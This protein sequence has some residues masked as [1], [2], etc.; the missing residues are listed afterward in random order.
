[1]SLGHGASI[2]KNGLVLHL[3][4]ANPKSYVGSG[5]S[6][7]DI[8]GNGNNGTLV[9]GVGYSVDNKG[10]LIFD[11]VDDYGYVDESNTNKPLDAITVCSFVYPVLPSYN[12]VRLIGDW[13]Q[14][15]SHDRWILF[16]NGSSIT[17]YMRTSATGEAGTPGW[18]IVPNRWVSLVGRYDGSNQDFFINGDFFSRRPNVTGLMRSG[19]GNRPIRFGQQGAYFGTSPA[20]NSF[21]GNISNIQLYNRALTAAE[22]KQNFEATRSRYGI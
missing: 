1:M 19:D 2:V 8:S 9:N 17:W 5:T 6:W 7:T 16:A 12:N 11:G 3:D 21:N 13:H 10:S 18:G 14:T 20:G 4:A 15:T 22:I